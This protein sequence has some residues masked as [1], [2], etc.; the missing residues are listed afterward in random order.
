MSI[1]ICQEQNFVFYSKQAETQ[2][3]PVINKLSYHII[4]MYARAS[5]LDRPL[6]MHVS[7][8]Y[9][10]SWSISTTTSTPPLL[11]VQI[12]LAD[13]DIFILWKCSNFECFKIVQMALKQSFN[14]AKHFFKICVWQWLEK[15]LR[16][17]VKKIEQ[18]ET[19]NMTLNAQ[20]QSL[21]K[22]WFSLKSTPF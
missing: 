2:I 5:C 16:M 22:V 4:S 19:S 21:T 17:I 10:I 12:S 11:S 18:K 8:T 1:F 6:L 9:L 15:Y 7:A 20:V 13:L 3:Y 14:I